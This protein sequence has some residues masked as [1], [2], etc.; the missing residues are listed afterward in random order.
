[1][2]D[3]RKVHEKTI[4]D[5]TRRIESNQIKSNQIKLTGSPASIS[6]NMVVDKFLLR[7]GSD[8][9]SIVT[10]KAVEVVYKS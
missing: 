4:E 8:G 5:K 1:M 9:I 10:D 7:E 6:D 2:V 3:Y